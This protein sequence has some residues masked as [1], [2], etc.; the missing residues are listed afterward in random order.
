MASHF[1]EGSD[2]CQYELALYG[3]FKIL[4]KGCLYCLC[5][6]MC[7]CVSAYV[8]ILVDAKEQPSYCSSSCLLKMFLQV[9]RRPWPS[10]LVDK[11]QSIGA[12]CC[13]SGMRTQALCVPFLTGSSAEEGLPHSPSLSPPALP[14]SVLPNLVTTV[15]SG[16]GLWTVCLHHSL[17]SD[18]LTLLPLMV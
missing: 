9:P 2:L 13:P 14:G 5:V 1:A 12:A 6:S 15:V 11:I 16:A 8:C 18:F 7:M 10:L 4:F 3:L 17:F